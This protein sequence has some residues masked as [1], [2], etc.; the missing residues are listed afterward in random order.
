MFNILIFHKVL[1]LKRNIYGK[2]PPNTRFLH[3]CVFQ[4]RHVVPGGNRSFCVCRSDQEP[5]VTVVPLLAITSSRVKRGAIRFVGAVQEAV[6]SRQRSILQIVAAAEA[7]MEK[8]HEQRERRLKKEAR[9]VA[10]HSGSEDWGE[11]IAPLPC[12]SANFGV[13]QPGVNG[14]DQGLRSG[15]RRIR[16]QT[17]FP[18]S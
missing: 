17:I 1:F 16:C 6:D 14:R 12:F 9:W 7:V 2:L 5:L 11:N 4:V 10:P 3:I 15:E 18:G 13:H 8:G